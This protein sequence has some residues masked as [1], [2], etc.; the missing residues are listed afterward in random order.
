MAFLHFAQTMGHCRGIAP[1]EG[2]ER[3]V[4]DH[5][6]E[7]HCRGIAPVEG[8]ERFCLSAAA[9]WM[10]WNCRGIAPVEGTERRHA[11]YV[12]W[13]AIAEALPRLRGLKVQCMICVTD[14]CDCRGIAPVEGTE[15]PAHQAEMVARHVL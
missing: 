5:R 12:R 9:F 7:C 8:T 6:Q 15:S 11:A 14:I 3:F 1:I 13:S 2:T 10:H 4:R